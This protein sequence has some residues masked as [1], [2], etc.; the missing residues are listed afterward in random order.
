MENGIESA[1]NTKLKGRSG[2]GEENEW[3]N[4]CTNVYVCVW[5]WLGFVNLISIYSTKN[6]G[7]V[8]FTMG[9]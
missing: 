8:F 9:K 2:V 4:I 1:K 6:F 5:H 3:Y 7:G